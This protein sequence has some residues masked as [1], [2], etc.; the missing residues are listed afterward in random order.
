M[1]IPGADCVAVVMKRSNSRVAKDAGHPR[2]AESTG[3]R[4]NSAIWRKAA[5]FIGWHEQPGSALPPPD[6]RRWIMVAFYARLSY[7]DSIS[8]GAEIH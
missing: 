3:N 4:R 6:R 8:P 5:A 2:H 1:R 7:P